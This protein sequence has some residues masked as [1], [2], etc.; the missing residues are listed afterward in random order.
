[1]DNEEELAEQE[2]ERYLESELHD[3]INQAA[4]YSLQFPRYVALAALVVRFAKEIEEA[5][6]Y[7][8]PHVICEMAFDVAIEILQEENADEDLD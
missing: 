7:H 4:Y 1:M 2:F 3:D 8:C 6:E 5:L